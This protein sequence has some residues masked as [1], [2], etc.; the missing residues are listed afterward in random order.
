MQG[1]KLVKLKKEKISVGTL[2]LAFGYWALCNAS[3]I[4]WQIN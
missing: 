2:V 1:M 3:V 4:N